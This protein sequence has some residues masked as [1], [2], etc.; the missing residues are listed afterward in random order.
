[1]AEITNRH[2][3]PIEVYNALT[4]NRYSADDG[5]ERK[6]DFSVSTL[7]APIQ[8]TILR[9]RYP[10]CNS[11][12][13]IDRVWTLFGHIAHSLLEEHGSDDSI[14]E[15]R[16]YMEVLGKTISGQ[17]DHYKDRRITDYKTTGTYKIQAKSYEDWQKQLNCYATMCEENGYP[18]D[19]IKVIAIL[20]DWKEPDDY[21]PDYPNAPIVEIPLLKWSA[22]AR[23]RYITERVQ[24]LINNEALPDEC[25]MRCTDAERWKRFRDWAIFKVNAEG[26]PGIKASKVF[27]EESM[28]EEATEYRRTKGAGYELFKRMSQPRK[29]LKYC[30]VSQK[31][32]QHQ[33][34]L[35]EVEKDGAVESEG[36]AS[37]E[38]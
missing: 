23:M 1:M 24:M 38:D 31:C 34:Y 27:K 37:S 28:G 8:Q 5:G 17:V 14:T 20:R 15:R 9:K 25:L 33:Q 12:D 21:K 36:Q 6:T 3:L 26:K 7:I 10:D 32:S 11:E 19:S 30:N 4:K 35:K 13:C 18:V 29:C 16:F 2:N 22:G